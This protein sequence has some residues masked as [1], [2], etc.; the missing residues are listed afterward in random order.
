MPTRRKLRCLIPA[1]LL[2]ATPPA[3]AGELPGAR[4]YQFEVLLDDKPIGTH[5][6]RVERDANGAERV[7]SEAQMEVR[8]L[9]ITLYRYRHR[10]EEHWR[11]GCLERIDATT[12]D[13]GEMQA[14]RG[15]RAGDGFQLQQ[16]RAQRA[17]TGCLSAYVYWDLQRL[18]QQ[19]ELLNP[20][21]GALDT[22]RI[23]FV[24]EE[25]LQRSGTAQPARRYRLRAAGNE[26]HLWYSPDGRWLQLASAARGNRQLLYRLRG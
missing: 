20:Q 2:L 3:I 6:Y 14:V 26:I 24:G 15:A 19:S 18:Q 16:P 21:T 1:G 17:D 5:R 4:D 22:A 12:D 10:A 7:R 13:N 25:S 9:G 11:D 8:F 23:E